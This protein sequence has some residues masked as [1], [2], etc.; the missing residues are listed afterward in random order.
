M[1]AA[2]LAV[3]AS[4][5]GAQDIPDYELSRIPVRER[6]HPDYDP[7]GFR[8]GSIFFYPKLSTGLRY[9]SNVFASPVNERSDLI[10][11]L[12]P[13]LTITNTAP[14]FKA[15]SVP[16]FAYELN[17]GADIHKFR[18]FDTEDRVDA[19]A[20]LKTKWEITHDFTF[21][22]NFLAARRHDERGDTALPPDASEPIPYTDLRAEGIFTKYFDRLGVEVQGSARRLDYEDILSVGGVPLAQAQRNGTILTTYVKP[23]YEFS[24]GYR[25]FVRLR[26]NTRNYEAV[27]TLNRDSN[28]YDIRGG[29]EFAVTPLISG[30]AEVGYLSQS[31]ESPLITPFDG[32]SFAA[33]AQ[34]LV[35]P[36]VTVSV[37]T[38]RSVAETITPDFEARLD[39]IYGARVDYELMRN[40]ILFGEVKLKKEEFRGIAARSD[41]VKQLSAGIE[42]FMNRHL[43]S[44]LQY[45]FQDRDSNLPIYTFDRH[46]VTFNVKAQY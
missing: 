2:A 35:T 5:A 19:R 10:F 4:D 40:V 18:R 27:G 1:T 20:Q 23:F 21:E 37:N 15:V 22:G 28:G 7:I 16:K 6:P 39:T 9:N 43:R 24:P 14:R 44:T 38:E 25:A 45:Q 8:S 42:Y 26:G 33:K 31:Y 29:V 30:S 11:I 12:S 32:L 17:V 3:S 46:M 41:D 36:L 34:W 13:E